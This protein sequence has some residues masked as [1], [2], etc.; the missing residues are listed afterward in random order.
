M[1]ACLRARVGS[2]LEGSGG[3]CVLTELLQME[4][5]SSLLEGKGGHP[6]FPHCSSPRNPDDFFSRRLESPSSSGGALMALGNDLDFLQDVCV[7]TNFG[8]DIFSRL[9]SVS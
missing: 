5:K 1:A 2:L 8:L 7:I 4:A 3:C 6:H 9:S